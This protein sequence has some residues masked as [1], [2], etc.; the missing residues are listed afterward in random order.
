MARARDRRGLIVIGVFSKQIGANV[1]PIA[2]TVNSGFDV[3]RISRKNLSDTANL[4]CHEGGC[5]VKAIISNH[6]FRMEASLGPTLA[7]FM[8]GPGSD[9]FMHGFWARAKTLWAN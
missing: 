9:E 6:S 1:V 5:T 8:I 7:E 2:L 4:E 3:T